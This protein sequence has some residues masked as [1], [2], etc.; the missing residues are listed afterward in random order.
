MTNFVGGADDALHILDYK[1]KKRY[2]YLAIGNLRNFRFDAGDGIVVLTHIA[3]AAISH[4]HHRHSQGLQLDVH[5]RPALSV[6]SSFFRPGGHGKPISVMAENFNSYLDHIDTALWH[7]LCVREG[8]LRRYERGEEYVRAG[9]TGKYIGYI[10]SGT[11]KYFTVS[12][13]GDEHVIGL[14]LAGEFVADF[15]F[16]IYNQ[17]S[18]VSIVATSRCEIYCLPV[19]IIAERM[20]TDQRIRDCVMRSTEAVFATVYDR[21]LALH[22]KTPQERYDDLMNQHP[23]LFRI[24]P[25]KDIASYLN[26]TPTHL[27]RLRKHIE[28]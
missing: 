11:L 26:I 10:K 23:D 25:L 15:P 27:S 18:R 1:T 17:K 2:A 4:L 21:Y 9:E 14:E 5:S 24:F 22:T 19:N 13:N 28:D 12:S 20:K 7:E 3:W 16:S 8:K 6:F